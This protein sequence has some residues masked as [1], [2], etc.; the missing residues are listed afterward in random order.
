MKEI[1]EDGRSG[2]LIDPRHMAEE[3]VSHI[4][5]VLGDP[6]FARS[7]GEN[8]ID[9]VRESFTWQHTSDR[10]LELYRSFGQ[11]ENSGVRTEADTS[12]P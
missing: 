6:D 11:G 10:L 5:K 4:C 9:R 3:L 12:L 2:L 8:G 7:L 1:I